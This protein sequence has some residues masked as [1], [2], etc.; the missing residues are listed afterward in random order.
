[1]E[2]HDVCMRGAGKG[3]AVCRVE[4]EGGGGAWRLKAA[5]KHAR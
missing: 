3:V 5:L 2:R 4:D 1:M